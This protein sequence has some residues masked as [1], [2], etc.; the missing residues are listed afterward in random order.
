[1]NRLTVYFG[2][3][4]FRVLYEFDYFERHFYVAAAMCSKCILC[5][6]LKNVLIGWEF[7]ADRIIPLFDNCQVLIIQG[8]NKGI[9]D[10]DKD[11]VRWGYG[12]EPD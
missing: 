6:S 10:I 3:E 2:T 7:N 5:D 9:Y 11:T 1:L 8:C 12:G 4:E